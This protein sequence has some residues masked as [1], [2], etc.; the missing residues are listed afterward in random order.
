MT[1]KGRNVILAEIRLNQ[2]NMRV[3]RSV[4]STE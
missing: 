1:L 4:V 2:F 3:D